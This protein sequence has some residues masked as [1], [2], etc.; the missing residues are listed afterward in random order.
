[1]EVCIGVQ[2]LLDIIPNSSFIVSFNTSDRV[3]WEAE[4]GLVDVGCVKNVRVCVYI[5]V[6]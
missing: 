4:I 3:L 2:F 1:M 5:C 6:L